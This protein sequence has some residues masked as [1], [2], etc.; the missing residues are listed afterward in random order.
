MKNCQTQNVKSG[1]AEEHCYRGK[2]EEKIKE[3][4]DYWVVSDSFWATKHSAVIIIYLTKNMHRYK[5][6]HFYN[7]W[8]GHSWYFFLLCIH[9][10][11][12]Y[13]FLFLDIQIVLPLELQRSFIARKSL[14]PCCCSYN[15]YI[16]LLLPQTPTQGTPGLGCSQECFFSLRPIWSRD[17]RGAYFWLKVFSP[18]QKI[19]RFLHVT[20]FLL[21][22][23]EFSIRITSCIH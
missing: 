12:V 6:S 13:I 16:S 22:V 17:S 5:L 10:S 1:K 11:S 14:S 18:I 8:Q 3:I 9:I 15:T 19:S 2:E 7:S 21:H 23:Y 4:S 20:V